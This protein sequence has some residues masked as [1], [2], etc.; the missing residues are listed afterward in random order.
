MEDADD[1][2]LICSTASPKVAHRLLSEDLSC[3]TRWITHSRMRVNV[4]KSMWF[5]PQSSDNSLQPN[6]VIGDSCTKTVKTQKYLRI[7]IDDQLQWRNHV[8]AV[9]KQLSFYLF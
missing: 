2:A 7:T 3:F 4:E 8:S 6:V 5:R 9:C 1:T